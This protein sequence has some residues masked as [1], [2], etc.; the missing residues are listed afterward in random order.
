MAT[1]GSQSEQIHGGEGT[2]LSRL[3]SGFT[4]EPVVETSFEKDLPSLRQS[5]AS[6]GK[7]KKRYRYFVQE[8]DCGGPRRLIREDVCA[9]QSQRFKEF[10]E[11]DGGFVMNERHLSAMVRMS[12]QTFEK[13]SEMSPKETNGALPFEGVLDE[14]PDLCQQNSSA[15]LLHKLSPPKN[16]F[17]ARMAVASVAV[18][19]IIAVALIL[20]LLLDADVNNAR[21]VITLK[22]AVLYEC[23]QTC[24]KLLTNVSIPNGKLECR[25][26][27]LT[28][29]CE[30]NFKMPKD[31]TIN[32]DIL[33][34]P[35]DLPV[36][37]PKVCPSP[38]H[39]AHGRTVCQE[40]SP[41]PGSSCTID[42]EHGPTN[43]KLTSVFCQESLSW[44]QLPTCLSPPCSALNNKTGLV[45][46]SSDGQHCMTKCGRNKL[47]QLDSCDQDGRWKSDFSD[48]PC[49]PSCAIP[50]QNNN[51]VISCGSSTVNQ[52]LVREGAPQGTSCYVGCQA[53]FLASNSTN[54]MTCREEGQWSSSLSDCEK[55]DLVILGG[56]RAGEV[57]D[58]VELVSNP[59]SLP[60]LPK[61]VKLGS[62]GFVSNSLL[63]CGGETAI[64]NQNSD[65]WVLKPG[66]DNWQT[67]EILSRQ[68][69]NNN[70]CTSN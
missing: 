43:P 38:P 7:D 29:N 30:S 36:C 25:G 41:S 5:T 9:R 50:T 16:R 12:P 15:P 39:P 3:D 63:V 56:E 6:N 66:A 52:L 18:F 44:S 23:S 67:L 55:T 70:I 58:A 65:C 61:K 1:A 28:V 40:E 8:G 19:T 46:C 42:C 4:E 33:T 62:A 64:Q 27:E 69:L 31:K 57:T 2:K 24:H 60:P 13:N 35:A 22:D 47:S 53:G 54:V 26:D 21:P 32:C 48:L 45:V 17:V 49:A 20:W 10:V 51:R 37:L 14:K 34:S 68:S 59:C 11:E